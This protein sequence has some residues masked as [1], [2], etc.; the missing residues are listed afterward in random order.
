MILVTGGTGLVGSHLL[1][2]LVTANKKVRAIVRDTAKIDQANKIFSYYTDNAEELINKIEWHRADILDLESL[3]S[4]FDNVEKVYHC[5]AMV[6]IGGKQ[7]HKIIQN[8]VNGTEHIVNLCIEKGVKK[9]CHVS[10]VAALGHAMNGELVDENTKWSNTKNSSAYSISKYKSEMEVWRGIQEGLHAVIVN[11]S[12]ILGPGIWNSGSGA[13]FTKA[14][15]GMKFYTEGITGFV[16]VRDVVDSMILL[17]EKD[18]NN[19]RFLINSENLSYKE[20]FDQV[21][22]NMSVKKPTVK[23]TKGLLF[24]AYVLDKAASMLQIK[25]QEITKEVIRAG[26]SNSR[27]SNQKII[28][29]LGKSFISINQ[30]IG[31]IASKYKNELTIN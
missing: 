18:I 25:K 31:F 27:Y 29:Q 1:Y 20:L 4:A 7:N 28:Q 10:S 8:N 22:E 3:D 2:K 15:K 19:E 30:S 9:L 24:I 26:N 13:L 11:P 12:V 23:A 6:A 16:D 21:A 14:A 5:A 17:M